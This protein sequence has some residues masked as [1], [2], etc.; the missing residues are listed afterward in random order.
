A[1]PGAAARAL[2]VALKIPGVAWGGELVREAGGAKLR[3]V[4]LPQQNG[5]GLLQLGDDGGIFARDKVPEERR[6]SSGTDAARV[7]L[8]LHRKRDA[9]QRPTIYTMG[10]RLLS[11]AG[12]APGVLV[13]DGGAR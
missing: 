7:E 3:H 8:V 9:V 5:T 4:Q 1:R 11:G 2:S 10:N 12:G 13:E 6:P